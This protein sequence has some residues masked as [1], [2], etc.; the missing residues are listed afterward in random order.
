MTAVDHV[1]VSETVKRDRRISDQQR[2]Q[3]IQAAIEWADRQQPISRNTPRA[4]K[5]HEE[6]FYAHDLIL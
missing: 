5:L 6:Q 2:W 3:M 1:M 4:C